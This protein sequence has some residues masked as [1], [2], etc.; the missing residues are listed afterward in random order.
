M[1][2]TI[3]AMVI[4]AEERPWGVFEVLAEGEGYKV[5]R[6]RVKPR[7]RLSLQ[8]HRHRDEHWVVVSGEALLTC[9]DQNLK[10]ISNESAFIPAGT[11][12]RIANPGDSDLV[13]IEVQYGPYLGEDD[14]RRFEDDYQRG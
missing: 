8:A 1:V 3:E 13:L 12:H 5:K 14:I 2:Y 4:E 11:I 10:R 9:G 7:Q 6:I